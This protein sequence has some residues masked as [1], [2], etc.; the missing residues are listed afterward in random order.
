M[1]L[2]PW[3][4]GLQRGI[5]DLDIRDFLIGNYTRPVSKKFLSQALAAADKL[6]FDFL[7]DGKNNNSSILYHIKFNISF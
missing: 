7:V 4:D 1:A 5:P 3:V 6:V 2:L